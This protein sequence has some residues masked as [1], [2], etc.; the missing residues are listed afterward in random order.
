MNLKERENQFTTRFERKES[1]ERCNY[2]IISN[3]QRNKFFKKKN[4]STERIKNHSHR[5][6]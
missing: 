4:H 3:N 1:G 5:V 2:I 6:T